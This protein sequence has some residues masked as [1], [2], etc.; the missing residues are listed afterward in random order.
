[1]SFEVLFRGPVLLIRLFLVLAAAVLVHRFAGAVLVVMEASRVMAVDRLLCCRTVGQRDSS[2]R[3]VSIMTDTSSYSFQ[4]QAC[5]TAPTACEVWQA[6]TLRSSV[7]DVLQ[8]A[9][10]PECALLAAFFPWIPCPAS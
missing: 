5:S 6:P 9:Q 10:G 7:R 1:M 8:S 4:V 3:L 2:S